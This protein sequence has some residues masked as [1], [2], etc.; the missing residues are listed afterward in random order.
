MTGQTATRGCP[1]A[2]LQACRSLSEAA[3]QRALVH[4]AELRELDLQYCPVS[5]GWKPGW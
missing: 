1:V 3:L 5:G 2:A 4:C